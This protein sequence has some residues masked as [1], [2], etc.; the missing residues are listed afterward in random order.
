MSCSVSKR[1]LALPKKRRVEMA[2]HAAYVSAAVM[3]T[4]VDAY[5]DKYGIAELK[6]VIRIMVGARQ[7]CTK[8]SSISYA[9]YGGRGIQFGFPGVRVAAEWILDNIGPRP[10]GG[11]TIDR[12]D[13]N[14]HYEPGNLRWATRSEQARNKR[15]YKRTVAGERI[16]Y[17]HT[18]RND[19][20][21][22]TIRLWIKQGA[23]N[24]EILS[25]R[26]WVG[27]GVRHK[28]LRTKA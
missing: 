8:Q 9:N 20:T 11:H 3:A 28:K 5:K 24:D 15:Q 26:K 18:K 12:I 16:R 2:T 10:T 14:R 1:M 27:C 19:L 25:K 21:Y 23:T 7:R 13:N 17:I 6:R 4:R 22:E